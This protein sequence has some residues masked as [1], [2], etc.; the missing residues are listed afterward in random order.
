MPTPKG[1]SPAARTIG[2]CGAP[3]R[4]IAGREKGEAIIPRP[5][6]LA[7][8]TGDE[9]CRAQKNIKGT[10]YVRQPAYAILRPLFARLT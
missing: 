1:D 8:A 3:Y 4:L 7:A 5:P 2:T 10:K 6:P 9:V